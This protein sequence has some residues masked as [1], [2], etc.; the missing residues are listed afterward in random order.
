MLYRHQTEKM[1]AMTPDA[2]VVSEMLN[3]RFRMHSAANKTIPITARIIFVF[4]V[5]GKKTKETGNRY[6]LATTTSNA[7]M[8][9]FRT[10]F[11]DY[12]SFRV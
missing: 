2:R 7:D 6:M 3:V 10:N 12:R 5:S 4:S 1:M 11:G 8:N 9:A